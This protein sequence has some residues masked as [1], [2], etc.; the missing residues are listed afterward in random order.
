MK[1]L[2]LLS[3]ITI[4]FIG[5]GCA[6]NTEQTNI[7]NEKHVGGEVEELPTFSTIC[8]TGGGHWNE[9]GSKCALAAQG[10]DGVACTMQCEQLCECGGIAGFSCP[11]NHECIM[12]AE[13]ITDALGYCEVV[14]D[15]PV[16]EPVNSGEVN[17]FEDCISAGNPAMESYPR[18]CRHDDETYTEN[19]EIEIVE[20]QM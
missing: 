9:C 7:P 12:E 14:F 5:G 20:L 10:K 1:K 6:K 3:I 13:G 2:F 11:A 8:E 16:D 15:K 4:F 18:Q 17:N 19:I